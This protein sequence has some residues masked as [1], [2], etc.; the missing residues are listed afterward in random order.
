MPKIRQLKNNFTAGEIDPRLLIRNDI[1]FF[2]NGASVLR[3]VMVNPQGGFDRRPG[4]EYIDFTTTNQAGRGVSFEFNTEQ[5]Y[6]I[7]FTP[8][9]MKVYRDDGTGSVTLQATVS[10]SPISSLTAAQIDELQYIQSADTLILFHPDVQPI[11]ITRTSHTSWT[12][13][14]VNFTNIPYF[15]YSG[16]TETN[17]AQT[18]TP[19]AVTGT[20]TLTAG[21]G[22]IFSAASVGQYIEINDGLVFI[23]EYVSATVVKGK[24][25]IDLLNNTA[26]ASGAW[27][28][29]TGYE[30]VISATRGWPATGTFYGGRL[31]LGGLKQRPQTVLGS[32]VGDFFNLDLGL[33]RDDEGIDIT[34][35]D[36]QVNAIRH[37]FPGPNLQIFTTGGEYFF[38]QD[39]GSPLT[40]KNIYFKPATNYGC[41]TNRP[42]TVDGATLFLDKN[43]KV[44]R[45]L[46]YTDTSLNYE[47]PNISLLSS[48]LITSPVAMAIRRSTSDEDAAYNFIVNSD[49]T[50]AVQNTLREQQINAFTLMTTEGEIEDVWVVLDDVYFIVKRTIN[51]STVR[52]IE[53]LNKQHYLDCSILQTDTAKSTWTGLDHLDGESSKVRADDYIVPNVTPSSGS[54]TL[55]EDAEKLE[56]GFSF[57]FR[58]VTLPI[59]FQLQSGTTTHEVRRPVKA[60]VEVSNSREMLIQNQTPGILTFDDSEFDADVSDILKTGYYIVYLGGYDRRGQ[61]E[62]T[63]EE[64]LEASVL[65]MTLEVKF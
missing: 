11:K 30:P 1:R 43:G 53:R 4:L 22:T 57:L 54:V 33:Q 41:D 6:S 38:P 15:A 32:N 12:A 34:I 29:I 35:D 37:L 52:C 18:L 23:T 13:A 56:V 36:D 47:A 3:N 42:V 48:H 16:T 10:S 46:L 17:P 51:S 31:W 63:Q 5:A 20:I 24:T 2:A 21:G 58:C 26:A 9:Q 8:G 55:A 27:T 14:V 59:D 44:L 61:V 28:Y 62:I 49:G 60:V 64:P 25:R 45:Q 19:S 40:P 50:C 39:L 65:G 7:V